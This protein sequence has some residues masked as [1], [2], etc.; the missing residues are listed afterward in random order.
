MRHLAVR[1]SLEPIKEEIEIPYVVQ[2]ARAR[3]E[4]VKLADELVERTSLQP[5]VP[6]RCSLGQAAGT[7]LGGPRRAHRKRLSC[8]HAVTQQPWV[9][10]GRP[11]GASFRRCSAKCLET[12]VADVQCVAVGARMFR[13]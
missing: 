8:G 5:E 6:D 2:Q 1:G 9:R 7:D 12:D 10:A 4:R 11:P 3:S 13:A